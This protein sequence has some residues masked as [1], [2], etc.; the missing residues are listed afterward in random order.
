MAERAETREAERSGGQ[1]VLEEISDQCCF[2]EGGE[3]LARVLGFE[4]VVVFWDWGSK[5][6]FFFCGGE[7]RGKGGGAAGP[8]MLGAASGGGE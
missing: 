7:K 5:E 1:W 2:F 6:F 8:W 4:V 3:G